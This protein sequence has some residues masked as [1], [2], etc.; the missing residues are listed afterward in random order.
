MRLGNQNHFASYFVLAICIAALRLPLADAAPKK[1]ATRPAETKTLSGIDALRALYAR[2]DY[3]QAEQYAYHM[4]FDGDWEPEVLDTLVRCLDARGKKEEAGVFNALLLRLLDDKSA[5]K[6]DVSKYKALAMARQKTLDRSFE[7]LKA[8]YAQT[9]KDKHFTSPEE[10]GDLWMTQV[11]DDFRNL[12]GLYAWKLVGGRKDA[13]PDWIHNAQGVMHRSGGKYMDSVDGRKGVLFVGNAPA[14]S[15]RVVKLGHLPRTTIANS[16]NGTVLRIGI[17]GYNFPATLKV[18]AGD[19]VLLS[20]QIGAKEW[21]DLKVPLTESAR[22]AKQITLEL[23]VPENQRPNEGVWL[24]YLDF[25]V[26]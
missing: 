16:G 21:S 13:K 18:L 14:D 26:D 5:S 17:K 19:E 20:Q 8:E 23:G 1:P 9:A 15:P 3:V 22:A 4:M 6:A 25:F 24:D 2:R 7:R 10:V 12:H 11:K